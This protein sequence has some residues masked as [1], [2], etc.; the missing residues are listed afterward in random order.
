M[1]KKLVVRLFKIL[2]GIVVSIVVLIIAAGLILNTQSIQQKMLAYATNTLQEKLQTRVE[3][4]SISVNFLTFDVNLMGLNVEDQQHREML[5]A[6]LLSVNVDLWALIGHKIKISD[7]EI[8]GVRARLYQPE[9]SAVNYQFVIDAFKSDKPKAEKKNK[10]EEKKKKTKLTLDIDD[11]EL[12]KID[13]IFNED[14]FYLEKLVYDNS[15]TG[16]KTGQIHQLRG[17]WTQQTKKGEQTNIVSLASLT[18]TD[19]DNKQYLQ[20]DSL[21]YQTDNHLPRK[22]ADKP[23]RGA[24]DLGHLNVVAN[25]ELTLNHYD[26]DSINATLTKCEAIDTLMGFDIRD[27]R[28][29]VGFSKGIA[30]LRDV[31][32]QQANTILNFEQG[33]LQLPSKKK[34]KQLSYHTSVITGHTLLKD[35]SHTFAPVLGKFEI[36]LELKVQLSGTDST[37]LFRDIHVN[38]KDQ[39]LTIDASGGIAH[40]KEKEALAIRFHVDKMTTN[41]KT[42][43]DIINQFAVKKF[44]MKQLNA[45]GEIIYTGDVAILY[46]REEFKGLIRTS[47]GQMNFNLTLDENNKYVLGNV[48]TNSIQ[49]GRVLEMKDIGA[50]ACRANFRFDISKPR[51]AAIRRQKGGKLPIGQVNA[52]VNEAS[53]KKLKVK[54]LNVDVKSDG[55]IATGSLAQKNKKVDLLCDFSFTNTDSIHKMKI[56]PKVKVHNMPWQKNKDK[57]KVKEKDK[58]KDKKKKDKK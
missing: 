31:T 20:I 25:L 36:P 43:Q 44:M 57:E 21:R 52:Q 16:K 46:K 3:I 19:K 47:V 12:S 45:L 5:Q 27:L 2:G 18:L 7:A 28:C 14:T 24:F 26:K 35:I 33:T 55:A 34:N 15:W 38:T 51:T 56:K 40:L 49:L 53:Y 13:I 39:K 9:D 41:A 23:K 4:D 29:N 11:L 8:E 30:H 54:D 32:I 10:S 6:D 48:Q 42:A 22:N 1:K 37:M 50:V 17:R 58:K